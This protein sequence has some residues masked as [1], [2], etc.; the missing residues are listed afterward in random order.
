M[1]CHQRKPFGNLCSRRKFFSG[2]SSVRLCCFL[3][4]F[5]GVPYSNRLGRRAG[6]RLTG[7]ISSGAF[8]LGLVS[9]IYFVIFVRTLLGIG[10]GMT[11]CLAPMYATE[12]SPPH[13]RGRVGTVFQL[14]I[15]FT[16][17][18]AYV[19]NYAFSTDYN[20]DKDA[21][22]TEYCVDKWKWRLQM[23]LGGLWGFVL[24]IHSFF[25]PETEAWKERRD[26]LDKP[27][28]KERMLERGITHDEGKPSWGLFFS[29]SGTK[30]VIIAIGLA[31]SQQLTGINSVILYSPTILA[32]ANVKNVL[33]MTFLIVGLWNFVSVFF[34]IALVDRL[35]RRPLMIGALIGMMGSLLL[36][37]LTQQ[38][39]EEGDTK[40]ALS[41]T[42]IML[43]LFSFEA[44]PGALFYLIASELFPKNIKDVGIVFANALAWAGNIVVS[45]TFPILTH[46]IGE[47]TTFY[48]LSGVCLGSVI[49]ACLM[50]PETKGTT[51]Q[52]QRSSL[53]ERDPD[54]EILTPAGVE[55]RN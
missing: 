51:L 9:N 49:F 38:L 22:Y 7:L 42:A 33:V 27:K 43:Y 52:D 29:P 41:I 44:G 37:G 4:S 1:L 30:W 15:C 45:L 20:T 48:M 35:G 5:L 32:D 8:L 28:Q 34:A 17:F 16:I 53:L 54:N 31:I 36:F 50:L 21:T 18:L 25:L 39:A 14:S 47:A 46:A 19:V 40:T 3:S 55:W 11:T 12:Q 23:S 24:F 10:I 6:L 26:A 2:E 13:L